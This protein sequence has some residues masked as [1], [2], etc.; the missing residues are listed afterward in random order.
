MSPEY[1]DFEHRA[2]RG[3]ED[4]VIAG[5]SELQNGDR[6]RQGVASQKLPDERGR[7]LFTDLGGRADLFDA[8]G[9][10]DDN[11]VGDLNGFVLIVGDEEGRDFELPLELLDPAPEF[12]ADHGVQS[13]KWFVQQEY[14]RLDS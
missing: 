14:T 1:E 3:G 2:P 11:T 12:F 6:V 4:L 10:H 9:I 5:F 13:A 8:A 7:R